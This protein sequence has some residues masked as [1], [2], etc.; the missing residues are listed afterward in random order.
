[1]SL[2]HVSIAAR[3]AAL[4]GVL[5]LATLLVGALGW[6]G[7][8]SGSTDLDQAHQMAHEHERAID[9]ARSAQ[10]SFKIQIQEWKN[11]LL[12]SH[13]PGGF[14]KFKQAFIKE[15]ETTQRLMGELEQLY[16]QMGLPTQEVVASRQALAALQAEYL[17]ALSQFNLDAPD[18][19]YKQVDAAVRG[20][21]RE[22]TKRLDTLVEAVVKFSSE[23]QAAIQA[24]AQASAQRLLLLMGALVVLA[25]VLGAVASALIVRSIT[26]PLNTVVRA[27]QAVSEG[28][29]SCDLKVRGQDEIAQL[30]LAVNHMSDSLR[31]VVGQ[32]R[33]AAE[34]VAHASGEIASGNMDLSTRTESQ[35]ATLQETAA[36][37][38]QLNEGVQQ[39][40]DHA[41][42][43]RSLANEASGVAERGGEVV[44]QV[45]NTMGEIHASS[46]K[47]AEIISVIDGIAF[48]TNILALNAAVEAARAGEQGRGFAVVASE[49]RA[50]AQRSAN[51]AREIKSLIQ[52][53]VDCVEKGNGLVSEAGD[54]IQA[55]MDAVRRVQ[56]MVDEIAAAAQEQAQG[57]GQISEA[58]SGIDNTMQQNAALVEEAA[59]AAT[60]LRQ[61]S[62]T[63]RSSVAFFS[64]A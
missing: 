55:T 57:I 32:V 1:M 50:L 34:E 58:V 16:V 29:L 61:Q 48:Q 15:G 5:L 26:R 19:S 43:A 35:A 13:Q 4:S 40:A 11:L 25:L 2:N 45:V 24:E 56:T 60:S 47:I 37:I 14:D 46:R 49:V 3:L 51:A 22:P 28:Q 10:V 38:Q 7:I 42:Q 9:V 53:S 20:K 63:L 30:V 52:A 18:E 6:A 12:R 27:A 44:G 23:R 41:R 33:Q 17:Q 36:T 54:T 31:G 21:D 8:R 39:S 62:D 64:I 59:A